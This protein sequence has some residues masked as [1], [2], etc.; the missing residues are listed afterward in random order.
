M[1][2]VGMISGV[3]SRCGRRVWLLCGALNDD[4]WSGLLT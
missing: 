3:R 2:L 1:W 4:Q